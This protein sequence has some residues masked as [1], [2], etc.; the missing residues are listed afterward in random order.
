[1]VASAAVA[2]TTMMVV[3]PT[4][5]VEASIHPRRGCS[6]AEGVESGNDGEGRGE[7]RG[8]GEILSRTILQRA[9]STGNFG[10]PMMSTLLLLFPFF[11]SFP[12]PSSPHHRGVSVLPFVV[13]EVQ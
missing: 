12:P 9:A 3:V 7:R 2:A 13:S 8:G 10:P 4:D 1:M 11:L 6:E 5:A